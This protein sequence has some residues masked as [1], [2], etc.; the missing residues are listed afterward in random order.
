LSAKE[1]SG[2]EPDAVSLTF[3]RPSATSWSGSWG[4]AREAGGLLG[5]GWFCGRY[6]CIR[7]PT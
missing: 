6:F 3:P 7:R 1:A 2:A 4:R 5:G